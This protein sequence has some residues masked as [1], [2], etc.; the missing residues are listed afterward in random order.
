M[1]LFQDGARVFGPYDGP[2]ANIEAVASG[3]RLVGTWNRDS[4]GSGPMLFVLEPS[5]NGLQFRG[6]YNGTFQW[7]GH[8]ESASFPSPCL[9]E[10]GGPL[11][12]VTAIFVP[13]RFEVLPLF[14]P[15]PRLIFPL[16]TATP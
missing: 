12:I 9:L 13:E 1:T 5:S 11:T 15:L 6:N 3:N 16:A 8:R 2:S 14:T 10:S 7:C 4:G